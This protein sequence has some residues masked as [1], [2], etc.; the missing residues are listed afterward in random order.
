[1]R[2]RSKVQPLFPGGNKVDVQAVMKARRWSSG[3]TFT[4]FY[5]QDLCPQA[6]SIRKT[7]SVVAAGEIMETCTPVSL[8]LLFK[9]GACVLD[10]PPR[11]RMGEGFIYLSDYCCP[12]ASPGRCPSLSCKFWHNLECHMN[13]S[14]YL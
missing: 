7:G 8:V 13:Y 4:S 9:K 1:M 2:A 3:G 12:G 11:F 14:N 6:D 5:L 10:D